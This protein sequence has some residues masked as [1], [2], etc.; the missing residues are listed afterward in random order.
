[1]CVYNR[2]E[3]GSTSTASDYGTVER[4]ILTKSAK[5]RKNPVRWHKRDTI[6]N[7][8]DG[9]AHVIQRVTALKVSRI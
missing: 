2:H 9:S 8:R 5:T 6:C 3:D 1:M 7:I 4:D